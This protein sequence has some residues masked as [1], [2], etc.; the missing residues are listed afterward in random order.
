M[1]AVSN[2]HLSFA[3]GF[4]TLAFYT[5]LPGF[6]GPFPPPLL[7]RLYAISLYILLKIPKKSILFS[8]FILEK[9]S[10]FSYGLF[11]LLLVECYKYF[12]QE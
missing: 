3:A 11:I 12:F 5:R 4:G 6:I 7:I 2:P 9:C 8:T 1:C 10:Q